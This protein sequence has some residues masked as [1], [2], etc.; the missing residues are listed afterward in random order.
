MDHIVV[1]DVG[2]TVSKL[3]L[4]SADGRVV[5]RQARTN[6]KVISDGRAV[7]DA[8]G[9]DAWLAATLA[10]FAR[11][12]RVTAIIPVAHGAAFAQVRGGR[13]LQPPVDYESP[14]APDIRAQYLAQ[15][16]S[17]SL[18]GSPALPDGLNLGMQ[19]HA[20][21]AE[22]GKAFAAGTLLLTW[23]QYWAWRLCG[24]AATEVS[25][26]GCHTD[27]WFPAAAS[28]SRLAVDRGWAACL[29]P[30][31]RA[32]ECLG[33]LLKDWVDRTGLPADVRV[34]CGLHDSNAALLALCG[35]DACTLGEVSVLSTG[36]WFVAMRSGAPPAT[37]AFAED[38]DCLVNVDP[39]GRPVPSARF[40]GGREL[41]VLTQGCRCR[42]DSPAHQP[43]VAAALREVLRHDIRIMPTFAAGCGPFATARGRWQGSAHGD[44]TRA[45][46]AS[47]YAALVSDTCLDLMGASD[48]IIVEGRFRAAEVF[49]RALAALRP[50]ARLYRAGA[51]VDVAWGALRLLQP[52]LHMP[53]PP[54]LMQPLEADL[55][56]YR[57][58]WRRG[59]ERGFS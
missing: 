15:R 23:P 17:F 36:T 59:V 58:A 26:L 32:D 41:E 28:P 31:R 53:D 12:R 16:D 48:A 14:V 50:A 35:G 7:L 8:A 49:L 43:L 29:A 38:R 19:L 54:V 37:A 39:F 45:A 10:E 56:A 30:L 13:L 2:K 24:V 52:G 11:R 18:T 47:L 34:Y 4:W 3:S 57:H 33:T 6:E 51:D 9:I 5:A 44:P 42:I 40:M 21:E 55:C 20:V 46:A 22:E 1:L 25:S 27:L